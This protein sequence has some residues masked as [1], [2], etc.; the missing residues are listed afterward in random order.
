MGRWRRAAVIVWTLVVAAGVGRAALYHLPRHCGCY[1]VFADGGRHWL[2][3]E[4][5]YDKVH[6]HSLHVFRYAPTLAALLS[7]LGVLPVH[8]RKARAK[9]FSLR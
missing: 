4:D 2:R 8:A 5:L 3:G 7:P 9:L 6:V 1:D